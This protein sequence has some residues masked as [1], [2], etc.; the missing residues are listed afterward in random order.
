LAQ[1]EST[2][3]ARTFTLG[4]ILAPLSGYFRRP[5]LQRRRVALNKKHPLRYLN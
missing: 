1:G 5:A 3:K 2:Q 4:C